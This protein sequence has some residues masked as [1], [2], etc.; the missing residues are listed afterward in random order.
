MRE[1][2]TL[3]RLYVEAPLGSEQKLTVRP[4]QAHKLGTVLRKGVGDKVRVFN[5]RD[6]EWRAHITTLSKRACQLEIKDRLRAQISVPDIE[7]LF[8]PIRKER[9]RFVI[10]KATEL[11]VRTLRPILTDRTQHKVRLDKMTAHIIEAAEQTERV[12]LPLICPPQKLE[13]LLAGWDK[14]RPLIFADEAGDAGPARTV[15]ARTKAP[16]A[17]LVGPEG[18]FTDSE[19]STLRALDCVRPVSLGPRI[20]RSDTAATATLA[21]WQALSGDWV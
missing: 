20:L 17:I 21:L 7:L 12:D 18:G 11:G 1:N 4:E 10:E 8:A 6:G 9:T 19:R 3:A 13:T 5:G 15:M 16:C 2:Y 14:N